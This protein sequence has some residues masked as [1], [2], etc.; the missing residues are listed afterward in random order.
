LQTKNNRGFR[1]KKYCLKKRGLGF[2][3]ASS[4]SE[5]MSSGASPISTMSLARL[6]P[7]SLQ[8]SLPGPSPH[9]I[10]CLPRRIP[11][12]NL[13]LQ[14]FLDPAHPWRTSFGCSC[15]SSS[16][17]ASV[18]VNEGENGELDSEE[19]E[20]REV[21][22]EILEEAGVSKL[23]CVQ[24]AAKSPK[25]AKMLRD[26]VSDLD[27]LSL[28]NSWMREKQEEGGM[29]PVSF[30]EK[31]KHIAKEKRDNG[32]IPYLESIGLSLPSAI[33]LAR[34]LSSESLPSLIHKVFALSISLC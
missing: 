27:E 7:L 20:L 21:V 2:I 1:N 11:P 25:Y 4:S 10:D 34:L 15:T 31:V 33:H 8:S 12:H 13:K 29:V 18:P 6:L 32:K 14:L 22:S 30:K 16:S 3:G 23:E 5:D 17:S 19:I 24:I 28:W 26:G 9:S